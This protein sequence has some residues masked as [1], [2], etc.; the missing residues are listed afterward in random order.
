MLAFIQGF[1]FIVPLILKC[2][3]P[4]VLIVFVRIS[5][6]SSKF[7]ISSIWFV[8][9]SN[10]CN[11]F[12]YFFSLSCLGCFVDVQ[13]KIELQFVDYCR[14]LYILLNRF[15]AISISVVDPNVIILVPKHMLWIDRRGRQ[16][17]SYLGGSLKMYSILRVGSLLQTYLIVFP[18]NCLFWGSKFLLIT[19]SF[20]NIGVKI[21]QCIRYF[22]FVE[23]S[24]D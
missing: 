16:V 3:L 13:F 18:V 8:C 14:I 21:P 5:N 4:I 9:Y 23:N 22:F 1:L 7:S 11:L 6:S 17:Y 10:Y 2:C 20:F 19:T 24:I 15:P 12:S